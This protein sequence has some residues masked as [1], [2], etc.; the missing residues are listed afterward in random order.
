MHGNKTDKKDLEDYLGTMNLEVKTITNGNYED[1]INGRINKREVSNIK[2][3]N[4]IT[5]IKYNQYK[6]KHR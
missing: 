5:K 1:D 6:Y 3:D 2:I 4:G